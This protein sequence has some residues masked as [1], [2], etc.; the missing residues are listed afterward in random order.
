MEAMAKA[1]RGAEYNLPVAVFSAVIRQRLSDLVRAGEWWEYKL[2]PIFAASYATAFTLRVPLVSLWPAAVMIL[3]ALVP[4]AAYVSVINDVTDRRDDLAAGKSNR[5]AGRSRVLIAVL[6]AIPV[7]AGLGFAF[8]WRRDV[9]LLSVYLA[10]WL[11][12]SLYSLPPFRWKTR[13][14]F[15]VL[16]DASGAHLFPTLVAVVLTYR[17][18]NRPVDPVWLAAIAV[19]SLAYGLRG[20]LWHQLTD[21][22][23]DRAAAVRTFA[24]RHPPHVAVRLGRFVA[25]PLEL[26]ALAVLLWRMQ[27][28]VPV[29]LLALYAILVMLRVRRLAM[30]VVIVESRPHFLI[31]LHEYY[32]VYFPI[33]ILI[34][35]AIREPWDL[36]ALAV[37]LLLFPQRALQ[38][39]REAQYV[40]L[41]GKRRPPM[42]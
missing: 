18:A 3:L 24:Q 33:G 21:R 26:I 35:S 6:I 23:N 13:G 22:E 28:V 39:R 32:D 10:A 36:I 38:S 9:L 5:L 2:V 11:A 34:A 12:F 20:I 29:A 25:F 1:D 19:W 37:H 30:H 4:G 42:S 14:I 31:L 17:E 8:L 7:A 40:V 15:G 16:A 41:H 27:S